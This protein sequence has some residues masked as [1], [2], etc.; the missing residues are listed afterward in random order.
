MI[1]LYKSIVEDIVPTASSQ[2]S[3][4]PLSNLLSDEL[5]RFSRISSGNN[6]IQYPLA[7]EVDSICVAGW[8]MND[9]VIQFSDTVDFA[10]II[11]SHV[12]PKI[13]T[14]PDT[15]SVILSL[16][17][18]PITAQYCRIVTSGSGN[19]DF[20]KIKIGKMSKFPH[21]SA[22]QSI[23]KGTTKKNVRGLGGHKF[24]GN[25]GY[26]FRECEVTFPEYDDAGVILLDDLWNTCHDQKPFFSLLWDDKQNIFPMLYGTLEDD[27]MKHDRTD[28]KMFPFTTKI[29]IAECF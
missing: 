16:W 3:S 10:V 6:Y 9:V 15:G 12:I 13:A 4:M 5:T 18:D 27:K 7:S 20:G 1:A 23:I 2:S 25:V 17:F 21:M 11:E 28:L 22:S 19:K 14:Q 26:N 24:K 8:G 29:H